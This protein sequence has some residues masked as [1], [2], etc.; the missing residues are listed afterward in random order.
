MA[1][2]LS[3]SALNL[4]LECRRCFWLEKAKNIKRPRGI[5]PSLPSGMDREIKNHFDKFRAKNIL[6]PELR[7]N[8]FEGVELFPDIHKLEEWRNWRTGLVYHDTPSGATLSGALDDLLVKEGLYIPFDYKTKGSPTT[9]EDAVKYYTNQLDCYALMLEANQMPVAGYAYLLYYSPKS[10]SENG[11]V[12]FE[13]QPIK[14][15]V[16]TDRARKTVR[17]AAE[18]I[19]TELLPPL[20]PMCEYC[21]WLSKFKIKK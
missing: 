2:R 20:N 5:F 18:L 7:G 19:K 1:A 16:Q 12:L 13:V 21:V 3:P 17:D 10:V 8:G 6:P 11:Q 15:E 4:F 14:V 9:Q